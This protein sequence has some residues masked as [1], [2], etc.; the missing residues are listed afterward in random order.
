[1]ELV[2]LE[3]EE[4]QAKLSLCDM[5]EHNEKLASQAEGPRQELNLLT[6]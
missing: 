4:E 2:S 1:M 3:G 6:P 5:W